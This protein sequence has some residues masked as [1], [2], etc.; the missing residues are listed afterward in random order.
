MITAGLLL[1]LV[2]PF[3]AIDAL[4]KDVKAE[5][6]SLEQAFETAYAA[7][8]FDEA[9]QVVLKLKFFERLLGE[10]KQLEEKLED[11]AL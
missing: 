7:G 10:I 3:D 11:E 5:K 8:D 1:R 6:K 9:K 4:S 2:A